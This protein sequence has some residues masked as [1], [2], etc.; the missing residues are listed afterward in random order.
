[1]A[2]IKTASLIIY[3]FAEKGLE[4]FLVN[5][6]KEGNW[7]LPQSTIDKVNPDKLL[8]E[9]RV[10][11]LDPVEEKEGD[12]VQGIAVESDWHEIPSLKSMIKADVLFVKDQVKQIVPDI[13]EK[14]T[15][16]AVKEA[17]K[18]VMPHQYEML[19]ELKDTLTERNSIKNI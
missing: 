17:F 11:A 15:Y 6:D 9:E 16:F 2:L 8:E 10:I 14:G 5:S 18:R 13:M 3:R 12:L 7:E 19:K 1:M 4:V